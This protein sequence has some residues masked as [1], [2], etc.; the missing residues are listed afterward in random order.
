M[1]SELQLNVLPASD[2]YTNQW[3][4]L[5][6]WFLGPKAE[7]D[8]TLLKLVNQAVSGHFKFRKDLFPQD[9]VYITEKI[10]DSVAYKAEIRQIQTELERILSD[11]RKTVPFFSTRYQGHM[12][13]DTSLP[14][15]VGYIAGL[16]YNQN[17]VAS[18]GGPATTLME[19]EA[20]QQICYMLGYNTDLASPEP[21]AWGHITCG[22]TVANIEAVWA[23]RNLKFYPIAVQN[24]IK[25]EPA[26]AKAK[27]YM[28]GAPWD[29]GKKI[30]ILE[31]SSWN[32]LNIEVDDAIN[33]A[34]EVATMAKV[35]TST[36]NDIIRKYSV[37]SLGLHEFLSANNI[38]SSGKVIA[39]ASNHYSWP[40][41]CT[42]LG[43][44]DS[45][46]LG[47]ELDENGRQGMDSLRKQLNY[48]LEN[49]IP[50]IMTVAVMGT[51][52]EGSIDPL[53]EMLMMRN[54]FKKKGLN[55]CMHADAA[56]GG[57]ICTMLERKE[58]RMGGS[59]M[60]RGSHYRKVTDKEYVFTS[61]LNDHSKVNLQALAY[62]DSITVDPHKTGLIPYP[63]GG[64]CY[65]NGSMRGFVTLTAPVVF[66]GESDPNI[67]VFGI[68]GS[69]PGAAAIATLLSHRV[70]GLDKNGYGRI[71]AQCM[72]GAK[73]FY[74]LWTTL[75]SDSDPFV[76]APIRPLPDDLPLD[77]AKNFIRTKIL[78]RPYNELVR[79]RNVLN[80]LATIGPDAMVNSFAVNIKG[81]KDHK[82]A[83]KLQDLIFQRLSYTN[84]KTNHER[85]PIYITETVRTQTM[86]QEALDKYKSRVGLPAG[87]DPFSFLIATCLNPW[88]TTS[89][90]LKYIRGIF[91]EV[92]FSA[93]GELQDEPDQHPFVC[94]GPITEDGFLYG[95]YCANFVTPGH[96]YQAIV[97][98]K[99]PCH[100][101][102]Q[103]IKKIQ[104]TQSKPIFF[105]NQDLMTLPGLVQSAGRKLTMEICDGNE[106]MLT[107]EMVIEDAIR[108]HPL[109]SIEG[110]YPEK[111]H[112][113]MF[114]DERGV[115]LSHVMHR[116]PDFQQVV[117]LA[118][119][120]HNVS[121]QL[122]R[123][124]IQM[125]IPSIQSATEEMGD[126]SFENPL[127][128][129]EY[130]GEFIG[131][132]GILTKTIL[133][134][135]DG[136]AN[137]FIDS[138]GPNTPI[139][140]K[141]RTEK[142]VEQSINYETNMVTDKV[143]KDMYFA[144]ER[145]SKDLKLKGL[146]DTP[147]EPGTL[148][149]LRNDPS[150]TFLVDCVLPNKKML[151]VR[152][153]NGRRAVIVYDSIVLV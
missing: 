78:S 8:E 139:V 21:Q 72:T 121:H 136:T 131:A 60:R 38:K 66:H 39:P 120:P 132:G 88:E 34:S 126:N 118:E 86:G 16:L 92:V 3:E 35:E 80:F 95:D 147:A 48:C 20:G 134:I 124:G 42:V 52:E 57:Y 67:G 81:N 83:S 56:W 128:V 90:H 150:R 65:R 30:P 142:A 25:N 84:T 9:K 73:M 55:F 151:G 61:P 110:M 129:G 32:L 106:A 152:E 62:T 115:Y 19:I 143:D 94:A 119:V 114:G 105:K 145:K 149:A 76:C 87:P 75:A 130:E 7:N 153:T 10:K 112:Y 140:M 91:R 6:A 29:G 100:E 2:T 148:V 15:N 93:I 45:N 74:C 28:V 101:N 96:Q 69:K 53:T 43:L 133:K 116:E 85:I 23:S 137:V 37:Q 50:V 63:A 97:K 51:T 12:N 107:V 24:A 70:I 59:I 135:Q 82:L 123:L 47:V 144:A 41:A 68:E 71:M 64:L 102:I 122:L 54:E 138:I 46:L 113:W 22:G 40:K 31:M 98:M 104:E 14:A 13:W 11:L 109:S 4:A 44:G 125:N 49:Q 117:K 77:V 36:F 141:K 58:S 5:G 18:E 89:N 99:V 33:M 127:P 146:P 17:N 108:V 26:L 1:D 79:D 111:F 27:G 103:K